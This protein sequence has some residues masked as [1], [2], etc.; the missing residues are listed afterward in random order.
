MRDT[1]PAPAHVVDTLQTRLGRSHVIRF[2]TALLLALVTWGWVTQATDPIDTSVFAEMEISLPTLGDEMV[3]VTTLPRV[4]VEAEGPK[5]SLSRIQ[6][7]QLTVQLDTSA[8]AAPGEYRLPIMVD[9]PETDARISTHPEFILVTVD[10]VSSKEVPLE[11]QQSSAPSNARV[12]NAI[13]PAVS[14]VTVT[15]PTTA[16]D[17]VTS[18]ILPVTIDTQQ[19]S[20]TATY[21]PVPMDANDQVVSE[22]TILPAQVMTQVE[23]QSRGKVVNVIPITVGQPAEGYSAV[24]TAPLPTSI[25]V[26]GPEEVLANLLFVN[27]VAVD[28]SGASQSVSQRVGLADLPEGVSVIEPASGMV[29]VRVAIQDSS[30]TTQTLS[31]QPI[32][33]INVPEGFTVSIEPETVDVTV[34]GS[35]NAI[36][37]LKSDDITVI[38]D[39]RNLQPGTHQLEPMVSLLPSAGVQSTGINPETVQVTI[40]RLPDEQR[41]A[42][43]ADRL[44]MPLDMTVNDQPRTNAKSGALRLRQ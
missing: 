34:Q 8:V 4:R 37:Q 1:T 31:G 13:T 7:S 2:L 19:T 33:A 39:A 25:T 6:R 3:I 15:G 27:T 5:S 22:V 44:W 21:V 12:V 38:V 43:A 20:F 14:Q 30:A 28:I 10:S 18:V 35:T 24:R 23:L 40:E 32:T 36:S 17:R 41:A 29:E 11:I 42:P 16:V 26:D 9:A